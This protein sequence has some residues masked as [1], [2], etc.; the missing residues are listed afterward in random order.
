MG[1]GVL[2]EGDR[3]ETLDGFIPGDV[4]DRKV[5]GEDPVVGGFEV[6]R[7]L[8]EKPVK[9]ERRDDLGILESVVGAPPVSSESVSWKSSAGTSIGPMPPAAAA[10][11][12]A[13]PAGAHWPAAAIPVA[14]GPWPAPSTTP[15]PAPVGSLDLA[16]SCPAPLP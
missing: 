9:G 3:E 6:L 13:P 4:E 15:I 5:L 11:A 10:A 16:G 2:G 12:A 1:L 7:I 8:E 14:A